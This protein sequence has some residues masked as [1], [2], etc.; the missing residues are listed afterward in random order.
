M[1]SNILAS[2]K[3][4][5]LG[6]AALLSVGA[7]A[8]ANAAPQSLI[9]PNTTGS[10][11]VHKFEQPV[12][13]GADNLGMELPPSATIGYDP[14]GGVTFQVQQVKG[15]DLT[16]NQG[17]QI[18][19]EAVDSFNPFAAEASVASYGLGKATAQV[20]NSSGIT[21]FAN[22]PV[23]LYL[24]QEI[25]TPTVNQ[26]EAITPAMPFLIT[27]PLTD[28]TDLHKWVYDVHTYPKNVMSTIEKSVNDRDTVAVGKDLTYTINNSIPGGAVTEKYVITDKLDSKLTFRSATVK[29]DGVAE[30][31]IQVTHASGTLTVTLGQSARARAFQSLSNNSD[32]KIS[33]LVT[34]R[35]N[36]AGEI[37]NDATLTFKRA[38][39][40]ETKLPSVPVTT[41]FGGIQIQ[42]K[43]REGRGLAGAVF[44]VWASHS[45][46][47][48][49]AQKVSVDG[50]SSWTTPTSG[51]LTI[52]GLRYSAWAN[53]VGLSQSSPAYF[54]Y[55]LV[56]VK[57]P[58]G[59]ELLA[60][61]IHFAVA[62]QAG[63]AAQIQVLN[64][65]HNAGEQLPLTGGNGLVGLIGLGLVT[66]GGGMYG[67]S[68]KHRSQADT[69]TPI[70]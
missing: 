65:P 40:L 5:A 39:E 53:G 30:K 25:A 3:T 18:A 14:L 2:R 16:T 20:T 45:N 10:I 46:D 9:P 7:V 12:A 43:D 50:V 63:A 6:L 59:Y 56:E 32:A 67:I 28:P 31:D 36:A 69:D 24:V 13:Y 23:G 54:H 33:V 11:T 62:S 55:W 38:D 61:P 57:A 70:W 34:A 47:F 42:K 35:V 49:S 26:G 68:R 51:Q 4:A 29:I 22:L 41:K 64:T 27:V 8:T 1:K 19:Q 44:E 37:D 52:A 48:A 58:A 66:L 17:W 15:V 21:K 60:E